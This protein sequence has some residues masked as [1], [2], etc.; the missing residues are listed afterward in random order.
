MHTRM[1]RISL[2]CLAHLV[3]SQ[4]DLI[5]L[6]GPQLVVQLILAQKMVVA[7]TTSNDTSVGETGTITVITTCNNWPEKKQLVV[8]DTSNNDTTGGN[9]HYNSNHNL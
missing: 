2:S 7:E 8:I 4:V 5:K 9:W 1:Q 6:V 3:M